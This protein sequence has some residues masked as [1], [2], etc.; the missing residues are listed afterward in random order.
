[1]VVTRPGKHDV[2]YSTRGQ[3]TQGDCGHGMCKWEYTQHRITI[4][5]IVERISI[6]E[7]VEVHAEGYNCVV[8]TEPQSTRLNRHCTST[9]NANTKN[10]HK[11]TIFLFL[12]QKLR[13]PITS[14]PCPFY[15]VMVG[16]AQSV[17]TALPHDYS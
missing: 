2:G 14:F 13:L 1:M 9:Q 7:V 4:P 6:V 11:R 10:R 12:F 15:R 17:F 3:P 5:R 16:Y 8:C